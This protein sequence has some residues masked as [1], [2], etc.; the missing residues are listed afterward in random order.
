MDKLNLGDYASSPLNYF[1]FPNM[2]TERR[3]IMSVEQ[4]DLEERAIII[5]GGGLFDEY[6]REKIAY[7]R[8]VKNRGRLIAWGVGHQLDGRK[9]RKNYQSFSYSSYL[10]GFDLIGIRDYQSQYRWVPCASCM[11]HGFDKKRVA[12]HEFVVYSHKQFPIPIKGF[13]TMTNETD[14]FDEILDFL[15]SGE[16]IITSSFHG[17]Y[18]GALLNRKVIVFPFNSKFLT[19]KYEIP[20]YRALWKR[21]KRRWFSFSKPRYKNIY[22]C[23][24]PRD[25]KLLTG[26]CRSYP[27]ALGECRHENRKFYKAVM[28]ILQ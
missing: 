20:M 17:M 24:K 12:E 23:E 16:S 22:V 7:L 11:Y 15:G 10:D 26:Q 3:D 5:G 13:P 18:W 19:F 4:I 9:W 27:E 28:D 2:Q 6:F 8:N 1:E 14:D 21:K 25:W